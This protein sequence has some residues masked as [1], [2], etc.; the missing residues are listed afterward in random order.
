VAVF[1]GTLGVT[2]FGIFLTPVF[3][4]VL[5]WFGRVKSAPQS[6]SAITPPKAAPAAALEG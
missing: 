2:L 1:S 6:P 3:F 4:D 5:G